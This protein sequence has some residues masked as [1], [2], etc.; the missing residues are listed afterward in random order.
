MSGFSERKHNA[1]NLKKTLKKESLKRFCQ[2]NNDI[3]IPGKIPG[4]CEVK[5]INTATDEEIMK[6][7]I[8]TG[9]F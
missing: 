3:L 8:I 4:Y 1:K 2:K 7:K 9:Y 6:I 5:N